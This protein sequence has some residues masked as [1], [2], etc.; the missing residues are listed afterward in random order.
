MSDQQ[1]PDYHQGFY[2]A[3]DGEP[4]WINECSREYALG[5]AAFWEIMGGATAIAVQPGLVTPVEPDTGAPP[6]ASFK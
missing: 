2:D 1:H 6:P 4:I 3:Q 5:W